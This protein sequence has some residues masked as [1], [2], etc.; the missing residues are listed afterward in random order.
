MAVLSH[1]FHHHRHRRHVL[2][3]LDGVSRRGHRDDLASA[4]RTHHLVSCYHHHPFWLTSFQSRRG[5]GGKDGLYSHTV[6]SV[7]RQICGKYG[8]VIVVVI[9]DYHYSSSVSS[10]LIT[11][12]IIIIISTTRTSSNV[13]YSHS[14]TDISS[15]FKNKSL[16]PNYYQ[17]R[18]VTPP[19]K[20]FVTSPVNF[21][22]LSL[23][24]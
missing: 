22:V 20:S 3:V 8:T 13:T 14:Q 16:T 24:Q 5:E 9:I 19:V 18:L 23:L 10:S 6:V 7:S 21:F 1:W 12:T 17:T 2:F 4:G 11:A 15:R